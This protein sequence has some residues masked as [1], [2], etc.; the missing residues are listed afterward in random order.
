MAAKAANTWDGA[1]RQPDHIWYY[2]GGGVLILAGILGAVSANITLLV[3]CRSAGNSHQ[4]TPKRVARRRAERLTGRAGSI[5]TL[6]KIIKK[7]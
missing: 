4:E 5:A 7:F 1:A 6:L 3:Q 2:V